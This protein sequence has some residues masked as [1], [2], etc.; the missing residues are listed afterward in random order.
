MGEVPGADWSI[1]AEEVGRRLDLR[2]SAFVCTIDPP[3]S[4]DVD[5][6]LSVK[7]L[8]DGLLS[9]GVHIADVSYFVRPQSLVDLEA[10]ARGITVYLP[11]RRLDMLPPLLSEHLC[12]LLGGQDRLALSCMWRVDPEDG[13]A[14]RSTWFGRTVI[15]SRH[16]LAYGEA[17]AILDN[18]PLPSKWQGKGGEA[19][20]RP[21]RS[22]LTMLL[23]VAQVG[24]P[25]CLPAPRLWAQPE[26]GG[27][28]QAWRSERASNGA[29]D[30]GSAELKFRM[31]SAQEPL[32]VVA[33][34]E[35]EM[36]AVVAELMIA[37]NAS[38]AHRIHAA[39]PSAALLRR[40][41]PP[42]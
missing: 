4:T 16:Q 26:V 39:F 12:S 18:R 10:R 25:A 20:V 38:V 19:G 31:G 24:S 3:G 22:A 29:L 40:H 21:I 41:T 35:V 11:E 34:E 15:H 8:P 30:L 33:K 42:M 9:V 5:D 27:G 28:W 37:A 2:E 7:L 23:A 36:Q 17:Q 6:A 13:Y 32:E 1:P 14:I